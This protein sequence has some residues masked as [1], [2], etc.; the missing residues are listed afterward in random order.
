MFRRATI[1]SLILI[2]LLANFSHFFVFAGFELNQKYI[3]E[4]LCVNKNRPW[5]HCDGRC[6]LMKKI[7]QAEENEKKQA[8]KNNLS[9][10][11]ISFFQEPL[12]STFI[13][14][15]ILENTKDPFPS[16]RS[17][18]STRY[19]GTIFQPPKQIS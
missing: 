9:H 5:L 15:V 3:A 17:G 11:K 1:F 6:Y 10:L 7:K 19:I 14:P 18:Y 2:T 13:S 4:N 8:A 16:Y 12:G